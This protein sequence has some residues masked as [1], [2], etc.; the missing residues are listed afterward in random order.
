[1]TTISSTTAAAASTTA[2]TATS[3]AKS[4]FSE[5]GAGDF[6]RLMTAQM[7]MQD[8]FAPVDNKEMLVQMAQFSSLSNQTS[9]TE[10]LQNISAKLDKLI[11]KNG[12]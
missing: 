8:P 11:A 4:A 6:L 1:M 2:N 5:L 7:Q 3:K 9:A 12:A 10:A